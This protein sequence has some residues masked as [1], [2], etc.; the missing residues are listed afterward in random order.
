[1]L[2]QVI[3]IDDYDGGSSAVASFF[4]KKEE[5]EERENLRKEYEITDGNYLVVHEGDCRFNSDAFDKHH[6]DYLLKREHKHNQ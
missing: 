5:I 2:S 3:F 4:S 1:M 6:D